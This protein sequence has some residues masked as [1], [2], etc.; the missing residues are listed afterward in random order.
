MATRTEFTGADIR[1][2]V[3]QAVEQLR[4]YADIGIETG[5]FQASPTW[6]RSTLADRD[7]DIAPRLAT[8]PV[9]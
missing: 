7:H 6:D 8:V 4:G 3:D 2:M 1:N 5:I 9:S